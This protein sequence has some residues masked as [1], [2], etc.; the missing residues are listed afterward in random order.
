MA[1]PPSG[2]SA[3]ASPVFATVKVPA[4]C[5]V[6]ATCGMVFIFIFLGYLWLCFLPRVY[7]LY[8]YCGFGGVPG[9]VLGG[10][11]GRRCLLRRVIADV[12]VGFVSCPRAFCN[13][14]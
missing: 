1:Y 14:C 7:V 13:F 5:Q 11:G 12:G 8:G 10:A 3:I 9:G 6:G 2:E 4:I